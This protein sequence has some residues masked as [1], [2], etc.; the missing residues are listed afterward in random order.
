MTSYNVNWGSL[1]FKLCFVLWAGG[2]QWLARRRRGWGWQTLPW[3]E[4]VDTAVECMKDFKNEFGMILWSIVFDGGWP[5]DWR[6]L[7]EVFFG[8]ILHRKVVTPLDDVFFF[9]WALSTVVIWD[10]WYGLN[11][12]L[13]RATKL[14]GYVQVRQPASSSR[15]PWSHSWHQEA[16]CW[17]LCWVHGN[18]IPRS[19]TF[20]LHGNSL[21]G[22]MLTKVSMT[23]FRGEKMGKE[24]QTDQFRDVQLVM[25]S[26]QF[27][28]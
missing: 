4:L 27:L 26:L 9:A 16:R 22:S 10:K 14:T 18:V 25:N 17:W 21:D 12:E 13:V 15:F 28:V 2:H 1:R 23:E 5:G 24:T 3:V 8:G 7:F 11:G 19:K 6:W 20:K